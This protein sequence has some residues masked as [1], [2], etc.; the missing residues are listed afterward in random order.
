MLKNFINHKRVYLM[1]V[2]KLDKFDNNLDAIYCQGISSPQSDDFGLCYFF[3][4]RTE[5][6]TVLVIVPPTELWR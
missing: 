5:L 2:I 3:Q 4:V 6:F 1:K